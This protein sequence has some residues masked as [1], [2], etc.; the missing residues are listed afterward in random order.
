MFLVLKCSCFVIKSIKLEWCLNLLDDAKSLLDEAVKQYPDFAKNWMM[1]GQIEEQLGNIQGARE[2]Y[3]S[4][5]C[6]FLS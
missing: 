5:G 6:F 4:V 1:K 3:T 2:A